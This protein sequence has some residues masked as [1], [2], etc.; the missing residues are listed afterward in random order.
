MLYNKH[1]KEIP[2]T[3]STNNIYESNEDLSSNMPVF[4]KLSRA[5]ANINYAVDKIEEDRIRYSNDIFDKSKAY[6][7]NTVI[8]DVDNITYII[9]TRT[10]GTDNIDALFYKSA[11]YPISSYRQNLCVLKTVYGDDNRV[12][13]SENSLYSTTEISD[14]LYNNSY[15]GYIQNGDWFELETREWIFKFLVNIDVYYNTDKSLGDRPHNIDLICTE[16]SPRIPNITIKP[17]WYSDTEN[18][19]IIDLSSNNTRITYGTVPVVLGQIASDDWQN[20]LPSYVDR[21]NV[22]GF[23]SEICD[24]IIPKIKSVQTR[25][26]VLPKP[27]DNT[28]SVDVIGRDSGIMNATNLGKVWFLYESEIYGYFI[29]SSIYDTMT[30]TQYPIFNNIKNRQVKFNGKIIPTLTSSLFDLSNG[31][32]N[33]KFDPIY[34]SVQN[35]SITSRGLGKL[36]HPLCGM[37][38]V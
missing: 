14:M 22:N 2:I 31:V 12:R 23:G 8:K 13:L 5:S 7:A 24:H 25:E 11:M 3:A 21:N 26:F 4:A 28:S 27:G 6:K 37:R 34:C 38:F 32:T 15:Y 29:N 10:E 19:T 18:K 1:N 30:S 33:T 17:P 20:Y 16:I 36:Y 35:D 9:R